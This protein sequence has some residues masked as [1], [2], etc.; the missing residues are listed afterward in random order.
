MNDFYLNYPTDILIKNQ[1]HH[2]LS[3]SNSLEFH[4]SLDCYNESPLFSLDFLS[5]ELNISKLYIKDE[6]K[7]FGL[8]AFKVLGASYAVCEILKKKS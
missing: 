5:K 4:S 2:I 3:N 7:R 1:T 6:S 8:N